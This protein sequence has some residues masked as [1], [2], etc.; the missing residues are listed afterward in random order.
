MAWLRAQWLLRYFLAVY[1]G[2]GAQKQVKNRVKSMSGLSCL[3]GDFMRPM[4]HALVGIAVAALISGCSINRLMVN[5]A[6]HM[7]ETGMMAF[8]PAGRPACEHIPNRSGPTVP[9]TPGSV[10]RSIGVIPEG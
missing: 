4:G 6:A 5:Q 7:I 8:E 10:T 9:M 1:E 2:P 3:N